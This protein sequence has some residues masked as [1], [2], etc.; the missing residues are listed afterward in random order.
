MIR[1][2]WTLARHDLLLWRRSPLALAS[3]L[4]PPLGMALL[5]IVLTLS[6]GKQPVALVVEANGPSAQ[7]MAQIIETDR[8][9][10][11]LTVTDLTTAARLLAGQAVAGVIVIPPGFDRGVVAHQATLDLTLNNIDVDFADDIRR[12]VARS[13]AEFDAPQL[14]I[15]GEVAGPNQGVLL[16]NA[17]RIAI[18]E[19]DLR[20]TNVDYLRYQVLPALVL[21]VLSLGLIG[22]ALLCARDAERG[23]ARQLT[24][25]PLPGWALVA[26]RLLG[27]L[28]A[29]LL[30]LAPALILCALAGVISPPASHWPA[31]LALFAATGLGAAGLG[32]LLGAAIPGSRTAAM[33]AATLASYLFFLGGGFTTIAFL[34]PWLRTLS[35]L[36]PMRYAIDGLRQT[37]FYPGLEGVATD[38][39]VLG[40]TALLATAAGAL[41]V[42]RS[43]GG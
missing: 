39:L 38:L 22:T 24:L 18:D 11:A 8:E 40:A 43:W 17:Y 30:V 14:G 27:G 4:I 34:P 10:Y 42:R 37:L 3:A 31:L 13:V 12:T 35:G 25:A 33:A 36:V 26:G 23:T 2:V 19:R 6:V 20:Q 21:L 5:L 1:G 7:L 29:S 9:A 32:A 28:L 41:A 15:Q 16:P